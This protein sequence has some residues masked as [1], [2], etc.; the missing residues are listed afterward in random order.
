[1]PLA[2]EQA[3]AMIK[4]GIPVRDF[5]GHFETQYERV[6]AQKPARSAWDY[7]K[8]L[9]LISIFN[10]LHTR[11]DREGDSQNIL[12]LASCFGPRPISIRFL[13]QVHQSKNSALSSRRSWSQ[14]H[15]TRQ[16]TWLKR[17]G[18][19]RLAFHL[20]LAQLENLCLVKLKKDC[21]GS[22]IDVSLHDSVSRW[23]LETMRSD[24]REG[25]II[26]AAYALSNCLPEDTV[27]QDSQIRLL[28]LA[29]HF[30]SL[31][32]RYIAPQR[33]EAPSG[34]LS[35][36]YGYLLARFANLYL[37]SQYIT[38][39]EHVFSQAV[40]YHTIFEAS[41]WPS[42]RRSLLLLK[43]LAIMF[44]KNGK[45]E[46]AA[47][48]TNALHDA[49]TKLLGPGHE[50]TVWAILRLPVV[51]DRKIHYAENEQR[52]VIASRGEKLDLSTSQRTQES[53]PGD[54]LQQPNSYTDTDEIRSSLATQLVLAASQG[55]TDATRL[56]LD[57]GMDANAFDEDFAIALKKASQNGYSS[58][59]QLLL[60]RGA[61]VN[62]DP[63]NRV[64][65][66]CAAS[67][68]GH[69][70]VAAML[71]SRGADINAKPSVS[72]TPL[73]LATLNGHHST[74][75]LLLEKGANVNAG[76][77][78]NCGTALLAADLQ[79]NRDTVQLLLDY[80]AD[81]N[82][83]I[84]IPYQI[85]LY[86]AASKGYR[87]IV[88]LLL[89]L[90]VDINVDISTPYK[91]A[92]YPA[93]SGGYRDI[94]QLL[95]DHGADVNAGTSTPYQ[96]ALYAAASEGHRD[97]VQLLLDYGADVNAGISIPYQT[98]LYAA[99]SEGYRDIVQ[100][101]L[102]HGA[103]VNAGTSSPCGT[104]LHATTSKDHRDIVQLLLNKGA[105]VNISSDVHGTALEVALRRGYDTVVDLLKSAGAHD[106]NMVML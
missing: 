78:E 55:D 38:E 27:D 68:G 75:Q 44:S 86:A 105:D 80:G 66:L 4:Q 46:D 70:D 79:G 82:A 31:I 51:R 41:S 52:A 10:M 102:N 83:G 3:R 100:L 99:A 73:L 34:K 18:H 62:Y 101:L 96:K 37:N 64:T 57:R 71:L 28:P 35:H 20:A 5:L 7:E 59:V 49:S 95:L 19:D 33:L 13:G 21:E 94:V 92:L 25:W 88:Q 48:T 76:A 60:D 97:I 67:A 36:Q 98:A 47:E 85:A 1:M 26:A 104:A 77:N 32:R 29:R 2:I 14:G 12:A 93:A 23:R 39:G 8:N 54:I 84:S 106:A 90:G 11:L 63:Q 74:V 42:G 58:V 72:D 30:Y 87:D 69:V 65:A 53:T 40:E 89:D 24:V 6:M 61:H 91:T 56:L 16:M 81:V 43:G 9:S 45:M 103:D 22:T 50:I 15:T 17:I